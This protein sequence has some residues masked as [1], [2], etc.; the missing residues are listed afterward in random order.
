MKIEENKVIKLVYTFFVGLLLAIFIGVGIQTFYSS[1][2]RP[3]FPSITADELRKDDGSSVPASDVRSDYEQA[4]RDYE[5]KNKV[6]NRNVSIIALVASI[7]LVVVSLV[8]ESRIKVIADGVMMGGLFTLLYSIIRA[9]V[10]EDTKYLFA[11][12]SVGLVLVLYLGYHRFVRPDGPSG[13]KT[14]K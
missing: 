3:D 4:Y 14:K 7:A 1:P 2:P 8:Y 5:I 6:Y 9:F 12:V 11:A 10:S 13:G